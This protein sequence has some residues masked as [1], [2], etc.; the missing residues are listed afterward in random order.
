MV[1]SQTVVNPKVN[2]SFE[3]LITSIN[4]KYQNDF[5]NYIKIEAST[6]SNA[7]IRDGAYPLVNRS[8]QNEGDYTRR[9]WCSGEEEFPYFI[10]SFPSLFIVPTFYSFESRINDDLFYPMAWKVEGSNDKRK[11]NKIA[12]EDV[13]DLMRQ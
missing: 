13:E 11:W 6:T 9:T 2:A 5:K 12:E 10:L 3:G 7:N 8:N 1:F 4:N